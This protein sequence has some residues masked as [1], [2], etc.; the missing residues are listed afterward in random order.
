MRIAPDWRKIRGSVKLEEAM[1]QWNMRKNFVERRQMPNFD[2]K[3]TVK[4][5]LK[6]MG[7]ALEIEKYPF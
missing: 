4:I 1:N 7:V 5:G 6:G 2:E 3:R